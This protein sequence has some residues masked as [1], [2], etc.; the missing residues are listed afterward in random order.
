[1]YA[2]YA[3]ENAKTTLNTPDATPRIVSCATCSA[4]GE[5]NL[6]DVLSGDLDQD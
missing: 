1:M 3:E 5:R 4:R 6:D 2:E